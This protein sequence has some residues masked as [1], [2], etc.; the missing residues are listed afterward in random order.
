M[1]RAIGVDLG[2]RRIGLAISDVDRSVAVPLG[3]LERSGARR[4]DHET[5]LARARQ[6][7]ADTL[8][9]G[10]PLTMDG[11]VGTAARRVL[12]EV[13]ELR[14]VVGEELEVEVQDERLSTV[15]ADRRM[16]ETGA[17]GRARRRRVD[18]SAAA[19]ILQ[20]YLDRLRGTGTR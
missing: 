17:G 3:T 13:D 2:E 7:A 6:E 9:V 8:V 11:E 10:L 14:R 15:T 16:A 20:A 18:E 1:G 4:S 5:L 12:S 19:V